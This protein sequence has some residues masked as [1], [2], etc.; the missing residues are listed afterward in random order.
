MNISPLSLVLLLS[1]INH[2]E[3]QAAE[4][5]R[6]EDQRGA[7]QN[8]DSSEHAYR[9][10]GSISIPH[11]AHQPS[12]PGSFPPSYF[13]IDD[14]RGSEG[15]TPPSGYCSDPGVSPHAQF[16]PS[17]GYAYPPGHLYPYPPAHAYTHQAGPQ[18]VQPAPAG[19]LASLPPAETKHRGHTRQRSNTFNLGDLSLGTDTDDMG[20]VKE[21]P[22]PRQLADSVGIFTTERNLLI[23]AAKNFLRKATEEGKATI[24]GFNAINAEDAFP[25]ERRRDSTLGKLAKGLRSADKNA[26]IEL[27]QKCKDL[28]RKKGPYQERFLCLAAQCTVMKN[29]LED[30]TRKLTPSAAEGS[31]PK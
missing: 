2:P 5:G 4:S 30:A 26:E 21:I 14:R 23:A 22:V 19:H 17:P 8:F 12:A 10:T 27:T 13:P 3:I 16:P 15:R 11:Q 31:Q 25:G 28:E 20:V 18:W 9:T 1:F 7:Y 6:G 29:A 24:E